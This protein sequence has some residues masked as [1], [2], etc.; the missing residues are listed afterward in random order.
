MHSATLPSRFLQPSQHPPPHCV[1]QGVCTVYNYCTFVVCSVLEVRA[2]IQGPCVVLGQCCES[3]SEAYVSI[4]VERSILL[5]NTSLVPTH[6]K[7]L[8]PLQEQ[9]DIQVHVY[10]YMVNLHVCIII[11]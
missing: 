4:P 2:E 8:G 3:I 11:L 1:I 10:M 6:F 9:T 7:W 5:V